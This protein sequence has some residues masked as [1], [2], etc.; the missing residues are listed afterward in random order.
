VSDRVVKSTAADMIGSMTPQMGADRYVFASVSDP[1]QRAA[2]LPMALATIEEE[3]GLS[4]LLS[5]TVAERAG[6][7]TARQMARITLQ[8]YSDLEG[9]GL[10]AAVAK[11]L[12]D[13]DIA[14]NMVAGYHHDHAFVPAEKADTALAILKDL[15][16]S[17]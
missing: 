17:A 13:R 12:A 5:V 2:L 10:T 1:D 7:P 4:L 14:C 11:A 3:E 8:V 16:A 15:Q 9:V 6:L